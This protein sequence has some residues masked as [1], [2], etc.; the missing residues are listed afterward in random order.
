MGGETLDPYLRAVVAALGELAETELKALVVA[1]NE[2]VLATTGL[3]SWVDH[4]ADWEL[5]RRAGV[6]FP[7]QPPSMAIP[8]E[9]SIESVV[10]VTMLRDGFA[11]GSWADSA[12]VVALFNAI[13]EALPGAERATNESI[14]L[15]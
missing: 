4:L 10:A 11:D 6:D 5:N 9:E 15:G 13:V 1:A 3:L 7:L 8:P 12:P 2:L 14:P